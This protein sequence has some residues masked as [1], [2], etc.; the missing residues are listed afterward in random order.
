[1]SY[2]TV[3]GNT[4]SD[5]EIRFTK[6]GKAVGSVTVAENIKRGDDERTFFHRVTLWGSLAENAS[7]LP[8]GTRVIVTGRLEQREYETREGEKRQ[9]WEVTADAFGPDAR[10][11]QVEASRTE[12]RQ[13][14]QAGA[15]SV[16]TETGFNDADS[17]PF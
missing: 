4:T 13:E 1:M 11:A 12:R 9:S 16:S 8:K 3:I 10:F 15:W 14:T 5:I 2:I 7:K 17:T 6:S